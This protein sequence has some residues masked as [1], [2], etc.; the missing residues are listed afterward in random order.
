MGSNEQILALKG[1]DTRVID[2]EGR[3][4]LPGIIDTHSH[5]QRYAIDHFGWRTIARQMIRISAEPDEAWADVKK[6][7]L[8]RIKQE[9]ASRAT[10]EW[11]NLTFPR[12]G[13]LDEDG[14]L[15]DPRQANLRGLLP[16]LEEVDE[17]AP[18]HPVYMQA[19]ASAITN[20]RAQELI[21]EVWYGLEEPELMAN[22]G[23]SSNTINRIMPTYFM[24]PD[25]ETLAE[26][27][28][29]ENVEWASFGIT[30]W[31]SSM[32]SMRVVAA[33]Q[34]LDS[35]GEIAIR[36]AYAPAAGTPLQ[37]I[38]Q[39]LA[40]E[41]YGS[42]YL[43][44]IGSSRKASDGAYPTLYT[45]IEPPLISAEIKERELVLMTPQR[46]KAY[47]QFIED[48]V[49][50]GQRFANTHTAGDQALELTLDAIEKGSERAGLSLEEIRAKRHVIDHCTMNPR[51]DQ[52]PRLKKL[53]I[54]MSCAPK[55]IENTSER[56]LR[57]YG[58]RY[59]S[60]IAPVKSL[61]DGGVK[62][63]LEIDTHAIADIGTVFHYI[64]LLVNRDVE[65]RIFAGSERIDR[66]QA[67]KM[68]TAWAAE[69]VL[70]EDLLGSLEKGKFA[71]FIVID[72]DYLDIPAG[73]L[74]SIQ[75]L[76]TVVGGK[77]V[78]Q[79]EESGL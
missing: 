4:V 62:P 2:V 76:L 15:R 75:A 28:R 60:W 17:V 54:M 67:L 37:V 57:D 68:S 24:I 50:A 49:A 41:D 59:V 33:Y 44:G 10:G 66:V 31:A 42:D 20:S 19:G 29:Q 14:T 58:E 25:I 79:A 16:S 71:D 35:R 63:V 18:N 43:W 30:T 11:I 23:V 53:G 26:I 73:E 36:V 27:Y 6:K 72:K 65:G 78:Y 61:I 70:R 52:I 56:V 46:R 51:P 74:G 77:I 38:P 21:R 48:S 34:L 55:Y 64:G 5:L 45:S 8:D 9:A 47:F 1:A 39:M 40:V 12:G 69:Y 32:R 13:A 22:N 3:T 7:T